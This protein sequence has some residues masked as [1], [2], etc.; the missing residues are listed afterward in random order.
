MTAESRRVGADASLQ[1]VATAM[2][3]VWAVISPHRRAYLS[4]WRPS[5]AWKV[6]VPAT[7]LGSYPALTLWIAGTKDTL[8]SVVC[9]PRPGQSS[10]R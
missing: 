7:L 6:M 3:P 4:A 10:T 5:S 9:I 8:A 2:L 1:G